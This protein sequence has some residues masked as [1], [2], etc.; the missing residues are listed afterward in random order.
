MFSG[1]QPCGLFRRGLEPRSAYVNDAL[2]FL[3]HHSYAVVFAAV[4]ADQLG[5]P[6][7]AAPF[8]IAVGALARSGEA[9]AGIALALALLAAFAGHSLWYEAGRRGGRRILNLVCRIAIEPDAC[10]RRTENLFGRYGL[11][12]LLLAPFVPG[13]G[14]VARPM[15]GM[16]GVPFAQ[17]ILFGIAGAALWA[18]TFLGLGYA[19][20]HQLVALVNDGARAGARLGAIIALALAGY[21]AWKLVRRQIFFRRLRIARISPEELRERL[22]AGHRVTVV[23]L[24]HPIEVKLDPRK[25]PGALQILP[26][27]LERRHAEI[28]RGEEVVLYCT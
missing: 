1:P 21:A 12:G 18:G 15:S 24:R 20:G 13:L 19:F 27:E 2:T 14:T 3:V 5:I 17:F 23:D 26:D 8:L 16:I 22:G 6:L 9:N 25:I 11:K 4:L 7:P 28:P 10:V